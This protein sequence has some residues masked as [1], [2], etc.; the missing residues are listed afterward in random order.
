MATAEHESDARWVSRR[1]MLASLAGAASS[2]S[3]LSG[4]RALAA[5]T[6]RPNI[7]L[8]LSDDMGWKEAGI[9]GNR[10]IPTPAMNAIAREGVNLTQFYVQPVCSPTRGCLMTG[11]YSWKTGTELRPT[12]VAK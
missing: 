10:E 7:V 11:R 5:N 6:G 4:R 9:N 8:F 12:G 1:K 3:A 2:L